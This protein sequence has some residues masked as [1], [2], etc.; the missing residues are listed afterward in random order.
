[1]R[2]FGFFH[3]RLE[4]KV[5]ILFILRRLAEPI[6][7]D[8]LAEIMTNDE[9]IGYFDFAACA[10]EL[11]DTG[12]LLLDDD[13]Y[14]LTEKGE[15]NGM[16]MEGDMLPPNR[17]FAENAAFAGRN[18]LRRDAL[19]TTQHTV[20]EDGSCA[21]SLAM[22]DGIG[23]LIKME[24]YAVN[25]KHAQDLETGYRRNAENVYNKLIEAILK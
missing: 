16:T 15:R 2:N 20:N 4:I 5:I 10:K 22:S 9:M 3:E 19:I 6:S 21:V 13:K 17:T 18:A 24:L 23:D 11:V 12:H 14:V 8:M 1:M 25:E 7:H